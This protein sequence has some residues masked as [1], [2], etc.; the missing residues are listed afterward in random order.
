MESAALLTV[1][2]KGTTPILLIPVAEEARKWQLSSPTPFSGRLSQM[3]AMQGDGGR[4]NNYL[5]LKAGNRRISDARRE[6][7]R[8]PRLTS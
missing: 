6:K 4:Q 8:K 2:E 7:S 3:N 1:C 5:R